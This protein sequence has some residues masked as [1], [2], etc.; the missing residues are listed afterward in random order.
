M[1]ISRR[2]YLSAAGAQRPTI[3]NFIADF[4]DESSIWRGDMLLLYAVGFGHDM[5]MTEKTK[6]FPLGLHVKPREHTMYQG[7]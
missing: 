4:H 7:R 2:S 1:G 5:R 3:P 6:G